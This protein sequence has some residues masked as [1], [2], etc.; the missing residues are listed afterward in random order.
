[1]YTEF[2]R[3]IAFVAGT[4]EIAFKNDAYT[5]RPLKWYIIYSF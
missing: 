4:L 3:L 2:I 5:L 1:M